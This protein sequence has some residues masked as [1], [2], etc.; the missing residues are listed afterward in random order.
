MISRSTG[1]DLEVAKPYTETNKKPQLNFFLVALST[2]TLIGSIIAAIC[3]YSRIG[4][5]SLAVGALGLSPALGLLVI[6]SQPIPL[7]KL[8]PLDYEVVQNSHLPQKYLRAADITIPKAPPTH[9]PENCDM[10]G[11]KWVK[12]S[13]MHSYMTY[14]ATQYPQITLSD[15]PVFPTVKNLYEEIVVKTPEIIP[16]FNSVDLP[17]PVFVSGNHYILVYISRKERKISYYDSLV[18]HGEHEAI[19]KELQRVATALTDS[20]DD[21]PFIVSR[22]ITKI[23]QLNAYQCGVWVL[24]F[25]E[26]LLLYPEIDFN[27]LD[28]KESQKIIAKYRIHVMDRVIKMA[29]LEE[30]AIKI[31][32]K[33]YLDYYGDQSEPSYRS[34]LCKDR[35][36]IPH[37]ELWKRR[38]EGRFLKPSTDYS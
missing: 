3:L 29:E 20:K 18:D 25:L 37:V 33:A 26:N 19:L 2:I 13:A 1:S 22:K 27:K 11:E 8:A 30:K 31:E 14:L 34:I 9:I 6:K 32:E 38:L 15:F 16:N 12:S 28:V 7:D 23:L 5:W 4:N 24:Y 36:S 17:I 21:K 10:R 35:F